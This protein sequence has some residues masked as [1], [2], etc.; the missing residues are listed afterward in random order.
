MTKTQRNIGNLITAIQAKTGW[1]VSCCSTD[2]AELIRLTQVDEQ[3]RIAQGINEQWQLF[4]KN[5]ASYT[6]EQ[7]HKS[8]MDIVYD[9]PRK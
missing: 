4:L 5:G 8:I 7:P 9:L 1:D 3:E 2:I 6:K